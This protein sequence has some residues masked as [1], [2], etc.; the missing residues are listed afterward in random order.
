MYAKNIINAPINTPSKPQGAKGVQFSGRIKN[1][2]V[3][4]NKAIT[5]SLTATIIPA[6]LA[7]SLVPLTKIAVVIAIMIIA[8]RFMQ[9]GIPAI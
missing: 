9:K 8:G 7:E 4:T 6:I 2:P 3:K 5:P 1:I